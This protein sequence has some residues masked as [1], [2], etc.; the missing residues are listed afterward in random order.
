MYRPLAVH[1]Q[2]IQKYK[3]RALR[4]GL[5]MDRGAVKA[6]AGKELR[7]LAGQVKALIEDLRQYRPSKGER[8]AAAVHVRSPTVHGA[9]AAHSSGRRSVAAR[10]ASRGKH[11]V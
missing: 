11:A 5:V 10:P 7:H 2:D 6:A 3:P 4:A 9:A 8:Y 1:E